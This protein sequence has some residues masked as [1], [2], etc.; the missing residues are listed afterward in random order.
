MDDQSNLIIKLIKLNHQIS[1]RRI[2][3]SKPNQISMLTTQAI[4]QINTTAADIWNR[5]GY[6]H[7]SLHS[8]DNGTNLHNSHF[9]QI[10]HQIIEVFRLSSSKQNTENYR[11]QFYGL[12]KTSHQNYFRE[13]TYILELEMHKSITQS[14]PPNL[15]E[16][17]AFAM[18]SSGWHKI[19]KTNYSMI[20]VMKKCNGTIIQDL[21]SLYCFNISIIYIS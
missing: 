11:P 6:T 7:L 1:I 10:P 18:L 8:T 21:S 20:K 15:G 3:P 14:S 19:S 5:R 4:T 9:H 2:Q 12:K 13:F 17:V 16:L